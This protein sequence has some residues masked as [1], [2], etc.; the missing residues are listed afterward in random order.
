MTALLGAIGGGAVTEIVK[1]VVGAVDDLHTSEEERRAA[2]LEERKLDQQL[3]LG[4]IDINKEEAKHASMFVAG[5]RPFIMWVCG[6]AL[7]MVYIPKAA[8]MTAVWTYAAVVVVAQW[9]GVGF[10]PELPPFPDLGVADLIALTCTL[11]GMATLRTKETL[12]G[13]AREGPLSPIPN[14]FRRK[15]QPGQEEAP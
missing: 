13:K 9:N 2:D 14:P 1:S 10:P 8:V 11:L 3:L 15:V 5:G 12:E 4:Q 7:A 6:V